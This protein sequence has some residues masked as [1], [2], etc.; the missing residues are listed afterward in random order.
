[1]RIF[2]EE[3]A[4]LLTESWA[5]RQVAR[6]PQRA[7]AYARPGAARRPAVLCESTHTLPQWYLYA[8]LSGGTSLYGTVLYR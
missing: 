3:D 1:M 4:T 7:R 2:A 8:S 6:P 5:D